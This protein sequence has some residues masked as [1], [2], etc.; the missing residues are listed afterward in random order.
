M[1]F[2]FSILIM[3]LKT[4][5]NLF[6]NVKINFFLL[7]EYDYVQAIYYVIVLTNK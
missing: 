4:E 1:F 6:E 2:F 3:N 7:I 5:L